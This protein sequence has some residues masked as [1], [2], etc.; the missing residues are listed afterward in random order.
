MTLIGAINEGGRKILFA[1]RKWDFSEFKEK[2]KIFIDKEEENYLAVSGFIL[3][4]LIDNFKE[5]PTHKSVGSLVKD[6]YKGTKFPG[7]S[8][9]NYD[10]A[11]DDLRAYFVE[12]NK[13][14]STKIINYLFLGFRVKELEGF[15]FLDINHTLVPSL[16]KQHEKYPDYIGNYFDFFIFQNKTPI[17]M[18]LKL[19]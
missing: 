18:N 10:L 4:G 5:N 11:E 6:S 14:E 2:K 1:D 17:L 13:V 16:R 19:C 8:F 3:K 15:D 7:T 9:V 12:N